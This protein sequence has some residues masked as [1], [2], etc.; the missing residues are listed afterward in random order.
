MLSVA[1]FSVVCVHDKRSLFPCFCI[2]F[3]Q[4]N[5]QYYVL[6]QCI[7]VAASVKQEFYP[8]LPGRLSQVLRQ[9]QV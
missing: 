8:L 5:G 9:F 6:K 4:P 2:E 3:A 7:I 1:Y